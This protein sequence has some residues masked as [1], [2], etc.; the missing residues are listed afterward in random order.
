MAKNDEMREM[1]MGEKR[2]VEIAEDKARYY[3]EVE[4]ALTD[5]LTMTGKLIRS[6]EDMRYDCDAEVYDALLAIFDRLNV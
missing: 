6:I 3:W 2:T 1:A 4:R 5:G